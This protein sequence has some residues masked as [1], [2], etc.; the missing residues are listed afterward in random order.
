MLNIPLDKI[1]EKICKSTKMSEKLVKE[2]I[3]AKKKELNGLVSDEGAA[4]II[5]SEMGVD[6]LGETARKKLKIK[7]LDF[8]P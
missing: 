7:D 6:I 2:K 8:S 3:A 4:Y 5:A 1:I